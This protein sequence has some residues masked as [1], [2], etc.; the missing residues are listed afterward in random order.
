MCYGH[1]NNIPEGFGE[2]HPGTYNFVSAHAQSG[3]KNSTYR[4]ITNISSICDDPRRA[5]WAM[6]EYL[7]SQMRSTKIVLQRNLYNSLIRKGIGTN[8]MESL[9]NT[10]ESREKGKPAKAA[11]VKVLMKIRRKTIEKEIK[12]ARRE[13]RVF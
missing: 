3:L 11:T 5:L 12:K 6:K 1:N 8:E 2:I 9:A 4:Q 7:K 13:C 10:A